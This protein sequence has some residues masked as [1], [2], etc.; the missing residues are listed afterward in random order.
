M[1]RGVLRSLNT[2][3]AVAL[4]GVLLIMV[5]WISGRR[6]VRWDLSRQQLSTLSGQTRQ[7]LEGLRDPVRVIVFFEPGHRLFPL[8]RDLLKE[9]ER[10]SPQVRVEIVD[11]QQDVARAQQLA[12]EL[13]LDALNL[14]IVQAA[15]RH[16]HLSEADLAE[17]DYGAMTLAEE[18]RVKAFK[19]A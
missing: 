14:V 3:A 18:P 1:M 15:T 11:P 6:H 5:T 2:A 9:Y 8:V 16:K 7:V 17:F 19:G 4:L 13:Q 10:L 12:Q